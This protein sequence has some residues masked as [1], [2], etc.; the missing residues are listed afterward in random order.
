MAM[1]AALPAL[2]G[3][4]RT[5]TAL[6]FAL[7]L[8]ASARAQVPAPDFSEM[9]IEDLMRIDV[10]SVS[11]KEQRAADVA[12]AV[13]VITHDDIRRSGMTSIPDLL[14]L[15]PGVDVGQINAN[16]WA[17]SVRGFNAMRANKLLVLVDGRS[18]YNRL[19]SGVFWD[20]QDV[21]I[22]DI[23]RIEVIRGPGAAIWGANAV[24]GVINII[25]KVAADTQGGL[26][27]VDGGLSGRQ[28]AARYGGA[29]GATRYRVFSQWTSREP[30]LTAPGIGAGDES[31]AV[32]AG[33]RADRATRPGALLVEGALTIGRTN[34]LWQNLDPQTSARLP[35]STDHSDAQSGHVL[36]RLTHARQGG[37]ILQFQGFIDIANRQEP[38]ADFDRRTIDVESQYHTVHG[39][40]ALVAGAGYRFISERFDGHSGIMLIPS[41][42]TASVTTAFIQ[43]EMAFFGSRLAVT[44][45]SQFQYDSD[46]AGGVQPTARAIW[47]ALPRQRVW[48]AASRALRTPSLED[49]G[50]HVTL[51]GVPTESGLPLIVTVSG[52]AA[53]KT[54]ELVEVE[55]GY[56]IE[57]GT[58]ASIDV[59]GFAGRYEHLQMRE[60][61]ARV[62]SLVPVPQILVELRTGNQLEATTRGLEVAAVWTPVP[63][64]R[65]D[66]NY[67]AF[68]INPSLAPGSLDVAAGTTDGA[69]PAH[70]W[71][72]RS[73]FSYGA[74]ARFN[75]SI[76][77]SG[78]LVRSRIDS[79]TR[80]DLNA[81][82][83]FT[84][85]LSAMV[86]GQNLL[87][88]AQTE[89]SGAD[90]LILST[91]VPRSG[92]VR[93]RWTFQ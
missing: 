85:Q 44:L 29:F 76:F 56:R 52:N 3:V 67:S 35:I 49:R 82:W 40:H 63:S 70:K 19:F 36:G 10:T 13:F 18:A 26:V 80:A 84:S 46:A 1:A 68:G 16:K 79:Y 65:I 57:I 9:S 32:T 78:P 2:V 6:V 43:D 88:E 11:R 39:R 50:I 59:T 45:G 90:S 41:A 47:K 60:P 74:R 58:R 28:G 31:H 71:Q 8:S 72:L 53:A 17:V 89:F 55:A 4:C 7:S 42:S 14:R 75:V 48:A 30:G 23:E 25:T 24:N 51:P 34:A 38:I 91:M 37:A 86:I 66:G 92:A 12:T 33:F 81:E 77:H 62:I 61:G 22:D 54:E 87:N 64:W 69:A 27:R 73:E 93:L 20:E 83:R 15:A 21:M 5:A